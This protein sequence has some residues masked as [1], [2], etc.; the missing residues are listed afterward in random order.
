MS[1]CHCRQPPKT[2][3]VLLLTLQLARQSLPPPLNSCGSTREHLLVSKCKRRH[4]LK[5]PGFLGS[6]HLSWEAPPDGEAAAPA[7][8]PSGPS[9]RGLPTGPPWQVA[10]LSIWGRGACSA[11][12]AN[13]M[14]ARHCLGPPCAPSVSGPEVNSTSAGRSPG[15]CLAWCRPLL[16]SDAL[17][18]PTEQI[19][20][21][22][23]CQNQHTDCYK[24]IPLLS[25]LCPPAFQTSWAI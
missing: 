5:Q 15:R 20:Q 7:M 24:R 11:Q 1:G 13:S 8:A 10:A 16:H 4:H 17:L 22:R 18:I 6:F 23:P 9:A 3:A 14:R 12:T 21:G 25:A 2:T 19:S